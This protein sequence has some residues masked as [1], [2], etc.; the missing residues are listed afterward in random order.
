LRLHRKKLGFVANRRFAVVRSGPAA[1]RRGCLGNLRLP[2]FLQSLARIRSAGQYTDIIRIAKE[3]I[4]CYGFYPVFA[5][6]GLIRKWKKT[7]TNNRSDKYHILCY[8]LLL[9]LDLPFLL[10]FSSVLYCNFILIQHK[11][12]R[13]KNKNTGKCYKGID[14]FFHIQ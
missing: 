12:E 8:S 3:A 7:P 13:R 14:K 2:A 5:K 9:F 10:N 1:T 11:K 6:H 4:C